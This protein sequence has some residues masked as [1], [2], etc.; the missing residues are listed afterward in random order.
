MNQLFD[1]TTAH[2]EDI[3]DLLF[4]AELPLNDLMV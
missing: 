4:N 2:H 1:A 3:R